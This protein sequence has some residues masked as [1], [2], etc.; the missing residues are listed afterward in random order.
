MQDS[1]AAAL[2]A[3]K[4]LTFDFGQDERLHSA[5]GQDLR[6]FCRPMISPAASS[7]RTIN[8]QSSR[9]AERLA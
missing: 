8:S 1:P 3:S 9:V 2:A 6:T 4:T 7:A 5:H